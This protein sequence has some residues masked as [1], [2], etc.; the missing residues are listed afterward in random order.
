MNAFEECVLNVEQRSMEVL[1][2]FLMRHASGVVYT[3]KGILSQFLQKTIGDAVFNHALTQQMYSAE[4]KA[5]ETRKRNNFFLETWSNMNLNRRSHALR[6]S[7]PGWMVTQRADLL[8]YHFLLEDELYIF[9]FLKLKTWFYAPDANGHA[10]FERWPERKQSKRDQ[11]NDTWGRCIPI[12]FL[13][14]H[15]KHTFVK[16]KAL[17]DGRL[18]TAASV[19]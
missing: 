5:E 12:E 8:L 10:N 3:N 1:A 14:S 9:N 11:L 13:C 15:V 4:I 7:T 18:N 6:G 17:I 16:P 2:P 19:L